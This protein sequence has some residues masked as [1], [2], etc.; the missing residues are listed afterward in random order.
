MVTLK[1]FISLL[2]K[3][4][5]M[6][7]KTGLTQVQRIKRPTDNCRDWS[8][9]DGDVRKAFQKVFSPN[10]DYV[11]F[12]TIANQE[13]V[14]VLTQYVASRKDMDFPWNIRRK[15][16]DDK[17]HHGLRFDNRLMDSYQRAID[18]IAK[19]TIGT[20][21]YSHYPLV[22]TKGVHD[23]D[24]DP[25]AIFWPRVY[26]VN[27]EKQEGLKAIIDNLPGDETF[28]LLQKFESPQNYQTPQIE[29]IHKL[30]IRPIIRT[31]K[32]LKPTAQNLAQYIDFLA[33]MTETYTW[34]GP[35]SEID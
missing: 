6:S 13:A 14:N 32:E 19:E 11:L 27:A 22:S 17:N 30:Q 21:N 25:N 33:Q 23:L 5:Q 34:T 4:D 12:Q 35:R 1:R 24:R 31:P 2:F 20:Q 3:P 29:I 18:T 26:I 7:E 10:A 28:K 9:S 16:L 15:N 8:F